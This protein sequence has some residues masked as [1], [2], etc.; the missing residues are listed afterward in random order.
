MQSEAGELAGAV[1][2][3]LRW[4]A[5]DPLDETAHRRLMQLHAANGDLP[6]ALQAYEACRVLLEREL[7]AEPAPETEALALRLRAQSRQ[8]HGPASARDDGGAYGTPA[9]EAPLVGR[10]EEHLSLVAL[11]RQVRRGTTAVA[12]LEGEPGIGK[13]RLAREFMAWAAGQGADTLVCRAYEAGARLPYQPLVEAL[14]ETLGAEPDPRRLLSDTWLGELSRL[15]P[16]LLGRGAGLPRAQQ[17]AKPEAGTA[18]MNPGAHGLALGDRPPAVLLD[19]WKGPRVPPELLKYA[20]PLGPA[21]PPSC[22]A[23]LPLKLATPHPSMSPVGPN[24]PPG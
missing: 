8:P 1:D 14:R 4:V 23:G 5:H 21:P 12:T 16:E 2:T 10:L 22:F 17:W 20:P 18:C 7:S 3:T 6:R 11:Y 9:A 15:L 13:T 24:Y 19:N